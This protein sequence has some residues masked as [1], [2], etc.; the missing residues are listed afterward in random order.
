MDDRLFR[1]PTLLLVAFDAGTSRKGRQRQ[2]IAF[3]RRLRSRTRRGERPAALGGTV[4]LIA[5]ALGLFAAAP[6]A[7]AEAG[8]AFAPGAETRVDDASVGP[9]GHYVVYLPADY[10]PDRTWPVIFNYH[11]H[12]GKPTTEPLK[13]F[14]DGKEF[15]IVGMDYWWDSMDKAAKIDRDVPIV[16]R[17]AADVGAKLK[18]DPQQAI[19]AGASAGGWAVSGIA[20]A[21]PALWAGWVVLGA[22]RY[23]DIRGARPLPTFTTSPFLGKGIRKPVGP[24][25][26][27]KGVYLGDGRGDINYDWAKKAADYYRGQGAEV[28]FE[29]YEGGHGA[30]PKSKSLIDFLWNT[31]PW[32]Q[33]KADLA[34]ANAYIQARKF[35]KAR[36]CLQKILDKYPGTTWA[37]QAQERL[38]KLP[39]ATK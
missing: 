17:L 11:G 19:I 2:E 29:T 14:L 24:S 36:E 7:R 30:Y 38:A 21:T 23:G 20:E 1:R 3:T 4:A 34:E 8:P 39:A 15:I 9:S 5:F 10:T 16:N 31:G 27:G 37:A 32:R 6:A 33:A 22:G 28:V 35:D 12:G 25:L 18:V 13:G 26:A